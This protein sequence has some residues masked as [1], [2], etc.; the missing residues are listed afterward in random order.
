MQHG[1]L[2]KEMMRDLM[3]PERDGRFRRKHVSCGGGVCHGLMA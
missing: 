3:G 2:V 1:L